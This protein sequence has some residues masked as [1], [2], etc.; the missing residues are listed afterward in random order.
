MRVLLDTHVFLWWINPHERVSPAAQDLITDG[1]TETYFSVASAWEISIKAR[2]GRFRMQDP[3]EPFI[4]E[5]IS[6]NRFRVLAVELSHALRV[7]ELL[8]SGDHKDP[9]D[10]LLVAQAL[11]EGLALVSN[12]RALDRYG[13]SRIW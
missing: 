8:V 10:R 3:F 4:R 9:F 11:V 7:H 13:V 2:T 5:Q 6:V 1:R 12:D